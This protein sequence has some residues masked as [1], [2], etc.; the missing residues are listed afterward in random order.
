MRHPFIS[1]NPVHHFG[2]SSQYVKWYE[3]GAV[4]ELYINYLYTIWLQNILT[5]HLDQAEHLDTSFM[6]LSVTRGEYGG[7]GRSKI[8]HYCLWGWNNTIFWTFQAKNP[9]CLVVY[10]LKRTPCSPLVFNCI[11][12]LAPVSACRDHG[13]TAT[14]AD[15]EAYLERFLAETFVNTDT[16]TSETRSYET[17]KAAV[18]CLR[19]MQWQCNHM[20]QKQKMWHTVILKVQCEYVSECT[21]I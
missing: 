1:H 14:Y 17:A 11:L 12:G 13:K 18:F 3:P 20:H 15:F 9:K 19:N 21:L 6:S 4:G 2:S 7:S 8:S 16:L 10:S 5:E